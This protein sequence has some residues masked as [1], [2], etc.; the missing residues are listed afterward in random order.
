M[1]NEGPVGPL[2]SYACAVTIFCP[3]ST[4]KWTKPC[5]HSYWQ[6]LRHT[7]GVCMRPRHAPTV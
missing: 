7:V 2:I 6:P 1:V 3:E 4:L 5:A